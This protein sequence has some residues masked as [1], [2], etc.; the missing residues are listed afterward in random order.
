[1]PD[2]SKARIQCQLCEREVSII[3]R[4]HLIPKSQHRR[5]PMQK[6]YTRQQMQEELADL[7]RA[8]HKFIHSVLSEKE[9]ALHFYSIELLRQHQAIFDYLEWIKSK[10][11]GLYVMT[12][13]R[14]K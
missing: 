2:S 5:K 12:R 4:H 1:M 7:C 13:K 14:K 3:T 10:P 6:R 9:L 8:C 11:E